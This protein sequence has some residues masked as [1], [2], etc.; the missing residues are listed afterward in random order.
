MIK[1]LESGLPEA[2]KLLEPHSGLEDNDHQEKGGAGQ[3]Q[4][5]AGAGHDQGGRAA[6][7][8]HG[9]T[10]HTYQEVEG[11]ARPGDDLADRE[12]GD[13]RTNDCNMYVDWSKVGGIKHL[14]VGDTV[15]VMEKAKVKYI[16]AEDVL[17]IYKHEH[18]KPT[19]SRY[20]QKRTDQSEGIIDSTIL[21][22]EKVD[23]GKTSIF[24]KCVSN[25]LSH[26]RL[27]KIINEPKISSDDKPKAEGVPPSSTNQ[28]TFHNCPSKPAILKTVKKKRGIIPDGL[29]QTRLSTFM[30]MFP[31]LNTH[32]NKQK[33]ATIVREVLTNEV[34]SK[35]NELS[36][37]FSNEGHRI[38]KRKSEPNI[39]KCK[40]RRGNH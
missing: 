18:F 36:H 3:V 21:L 15:M 30:K 12:Q 11:E 1:T 20:G 38:G 26:I 29:V 19:C 9:G 37:D 4:G 32:L 22:A 33:G 35:S 14:E 8:R 5:L 16:P 13:G 31:N 27:N 40:R 2:K 24:N 28:I 6:Q 17:P 34:L 23:G 7:H 10:Q 25:N 39:A